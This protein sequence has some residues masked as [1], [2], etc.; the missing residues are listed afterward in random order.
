MRLTG[1]GRHVFT[2]ALGPV[3]LAWTPRA[4]AGLRSGNPT[5]RPHWRRWPSG[6]PD[7]PVVAR[8]P[9]AVA[10][11]AARVRASLRGAADDFADVPL[12]PG[13][14]PP[15]ARAVWQRLRKVPRRQVIT[16]GELA[17]ACGR[18]RP[19]ARSGASWAPTR[20]R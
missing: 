11:L 6:V 15:F 12:D 8:P 10:A 3:G 7:L 17:A 18:P 2:T 19:R 13:D 1:T 16:Y 4:C 5:G 9:A 20:C 14:A